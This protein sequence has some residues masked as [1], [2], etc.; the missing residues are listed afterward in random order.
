MNYQQNEM[1]ID[2]AKDITSIESALKS[3]WEKAHAAT[4][5][6]AKYRHENDI[7][8]ENHS[9][10]DKEVKTLRIELLEKEQELKKL[11]AEHNRVINAAPSDG[12]VHEEK[13]YLKNKIRELLVKIN[14]HL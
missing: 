14:S 6:I 3:F 12:F 8:K 9:A 13:E 7:L 5:I 10:L 1:D 2:V 11:H 4:D